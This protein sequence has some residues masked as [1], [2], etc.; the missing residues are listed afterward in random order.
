MFVQHRECGQYFVVIVDGAY[1][2][3]KNCVFK[4]VWSVPVLSFGPQ[5]C[6]NFPYWNFPGELLDCGWGSLGPF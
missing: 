2:T 4:E 6:D 1:L 3:F 5:F